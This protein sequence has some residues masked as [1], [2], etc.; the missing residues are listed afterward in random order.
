[1]KI[2]VVIPYFYPSVGGLQ[3]YALFISKGLQQ[4]GH[5]IIIIT[6]NHTEKK[7][8][9]E[10][11]KNLKIYRLVID[12]KISNTPIGFRWFGDIERIIKDEK[13]DVINAHTPVPYI[14][15]IAAIVAKKNN[16]PFVLTYQNDLIKDNFFLNLMINM[17]YA[18]LGIPTLK[19]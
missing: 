7:Y 9:I 15:D 3:N 8:I 12:W 2:L 6:A 4:L 16:I 17:Y 13:P 14:S 11:N 1:M 10:T 5:E 18:T 19:I